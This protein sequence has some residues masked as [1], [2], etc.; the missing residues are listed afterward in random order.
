MPEMTPRTLE[1]ALSGHYDVVA[2][3]H[4]PGIDVQIRNYSIPPAEQLR[5]C[6]PRFVLGSQLTPFP[7]PSQGHYA[8]AKP[9]Q[10]TNIGGL[11]FTP[12]G[13]PWTIRTAGGQFRSM[14]CEYD[15]EIFKAITGRNDDWSDR[16][17]SISHNIQNPWIAQVMQRL[18]TEAVSPGFASDI[19]VEVL[20][21]SLIVELARHFQNIP[22]GQGGLGSGLEPWQ[23]ERIDN[24]VAEISGAPPTLGQMATLCG[25][26][27][28][29]FMRRFK[30]SKGQTVSNYLRQQQT[31]KAQMLLTRTKLPLK[32]VSF[33]LGFSSLSNFTFAFRRETG[34][35]PKQF[36]GRYS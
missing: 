8:P 1:P 22:A 11:V 28:R 10:F 6:H 35:T 2:G 21:T 30:A 5:V 27:S 12:A 32:E 31:A 7:K 9:G 36:R 13:L 16:E 25:L 34:D 4:A 3:L 19:L 23:L 17:L 33:R 26:G 18:A 20:A 15:A 24:Y 14:A 29:T